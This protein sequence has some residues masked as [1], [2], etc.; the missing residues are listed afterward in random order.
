MFCEFTIYMFY[1]TGFI[2]FRSSL[3]PPKLF[4]WYTV[5][6]FKTFQQNPTIFKKGLYNEKWS[7]SSSLAMCSSY[8]FWCSSLNWATQQAASCSKYLT[9]PQKMRR[10]N[11]YLPCFVLIWWTSCPQWA[12]QGNSVAYTGLVD[13]K[14][15]QWDNLVLQYIFSLEWYSH[16][17]HLLTRYKR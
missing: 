6:S 7:E 12:L 17:L 16:D 3:Y 14:D 10:R 5:N 4:Y 2:L 8:Y 13:L 1:E 15:K 11:P 9:F